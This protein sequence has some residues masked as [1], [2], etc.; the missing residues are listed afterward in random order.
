MRRRLA[1][2]L[3]LVSFSSSTWACEPNLEDASMK[4]YLQKATADTVVFAARV[5]SIEEH[6][7]HGV[8]VQTA[9]LRTSRWWR[10]K[11]M[12]EVLVIGEKGR[13]AGTSCFGVFDFVMKEGEEWLIVGQ[14]KDGKISP[15]KFLSQLM[16]EKEA[17][18]KSLSDLSKF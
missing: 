16:S 14:M 9:Q 2:T 3:C 7:E 13:G 17:K 5:V 12:P 8:L 1:L 15:A 18:T 11:Q 10:G 4:R 6:K